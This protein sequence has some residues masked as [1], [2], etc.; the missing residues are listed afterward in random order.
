MK[1]EKQGEKDEGKNEAF[2]RN[3][4]D[5]WFE[6]IAAEKLSRGRRIARRGG[7][8]KIRAARKS[9]IVRIISQFIQ[10]DSGAYLS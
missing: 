1:Y 2:H 9:I 10:P 4:S 5:E 7:D 3:T 6:I 8:Y